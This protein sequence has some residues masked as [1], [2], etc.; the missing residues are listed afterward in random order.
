MRKTLTLTLAAGLAYACPPRISAHELFH[1]ARE[2]QTAK[3]GGPALAREADRAARDYS[4]ARHVLSPPHQGL[5]GL[6][7]KLKTTNFKK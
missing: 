7:I 2:A 4:A 1:V 5:R 6:V 3:C